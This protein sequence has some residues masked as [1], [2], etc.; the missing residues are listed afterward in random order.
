MILDLLHQ[1]QTAI[2]D[3]LPWLESV[4]LNDVKDVSFDDICDRLFG[5]LRDGIDQD[6]DNPFRPDLDVHHIDRRLSPSLARICDAPVAAAFS[7]DG[8][9]ELT[10][11]QIMTLKDVRENHPQFFGEAYAFA[12]ANLT[13]E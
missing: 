11:A 8:K 6:R 4:L 13:G 10:K 3:A 2:V 5:R 1:Q 9:L 12:L 7:A